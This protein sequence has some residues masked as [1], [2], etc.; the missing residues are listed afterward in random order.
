[1]FTNYHF[2]HFFAVDCG[3]CVQVFEWCICFFET[4]EVSLKDN[5]R[6]EGYIYGPYIEA[7]L[8]HIRVD[9]PKSSLGDNFEKAF[10]M[11]RSLSL[12]YLQMM[13]LLCLYHLYSIDLNIIWYTC[14]LQMIPVVFVSSTWT[15]QST[16]PLCINEC[17]TKPLL[18]GY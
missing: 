9:E 2:L 18:V 10:N 14:V 6:V 7:D 3:C 13:I 4:D 17:A 11:K 8:E 12:T 1:M 5:L 16:I 15:C